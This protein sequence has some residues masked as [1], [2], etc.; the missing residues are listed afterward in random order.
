MT[1]KIDVI[2]EIRYNI[3]F[4]IEANSKEEAKRIIRDDIVEGEIKN[5]EITDFEIVDIE[6]Q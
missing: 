3:T 2:E 1:Y 5:Q 4:E 6:E